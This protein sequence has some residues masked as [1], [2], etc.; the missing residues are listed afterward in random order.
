MFDVRRP[1]F[2]LAPLLL[3]FALTPSHPQPAGP[4]RPPGGIYNP[5]RPLVRQGPLPAAVQQALQGILLFPAQAAAL[6]APVT[7]SPLHPVTLS[8]A[9][10]SPVHPLT[11]A[12]VHPLTGSPAHPPTP[13]GV[14]Q[15]SILYLTRLQAGDHA[16]EVMEWLRGLPK[17]QVVSLLEKTPWRKD[18][19]AV[20]DALVQVL[21]ETHR[22]APATADELPPLCALRVA[23]S[24]GSHGDKRCEPVFERLLDQHRANEA[25]AVPAVLAFAEYYRSVGEH[26][27]SAATFLRAKDYTKANNTLAN[28][29]VEAAREYMQAENEGEAERLYEE[30]P[31][32]GYGWATGL[33]LYD[34]ARRL[35][36]LGRQ[37]E[38]RRL[39]QQPVSGQY[40]DQVKVALLRQLGYSFYLTG[41]F[42]KAREYCRAAIEQ[43][44]SLPN[45]LAGEGL[46]TEVAIAESIITW[47]SRWSKGSIYCE[48]QMLRMA[49]GSQ[50]IPGGR[51]VTR[52]LII[53]TPKPIRLVV[54]ADDSRVETELADKVVQ[55]YYFAQREATV[56]LNT[57]EKTK[58]FRATV[59]VTSPDAPNSQV[60]V[61]VVVEAQQ[62]IRLSTPVAFFGSIV[63]GSTGTTVVR[64]SSETPFRVVEV[65]PDSAAVHATV[66]DPQEANEHEIEF[67]FSPGP[68]L[69]GRICEG[70]VRVVTTVGG[71]EVID[72]PYMARVR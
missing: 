4:P 9:V 35:V 61:P 14:D 59:R 31:K 30:V 15:R 62:P 43:Y 16:P 3:C 56:S 17:E 49:A 68:A 25:L 54:A 32:Y 46:D 70:Q 64:L 26:A 53:R 19:H 10:P 44:Q 48:Q 8:G 1:T 69:A 55:T 36:D 42:E 6:P 7:V 5:Y 41:D 28:C 57:G 38:A 65:Q 63:S 67:S 24:L 45:P 58:G 34:Q 21:L 23:Q 29:T 47:S 27:K 40:A 39:L 33:A 51:P 60:E 12:A 13:S 71:K 20:C 72:I 22:L 66:R 18:D 50:A 52:R 37:D 11:S 2:A